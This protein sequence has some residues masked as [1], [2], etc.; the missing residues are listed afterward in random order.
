M[1]IQQIYLLLILQ[2]HVNISQNQSENL[3][4]SKKLKVAKLIKPMMKIAK[5][6]SFLSRFRIFKA[7]KG[8]NDF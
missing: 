2:R 8:E 3:K 1:A 6:L 7:L 5:K 4:K